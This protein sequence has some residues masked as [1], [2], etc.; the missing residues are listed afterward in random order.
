MELLRLRSICRRRISND[1][2]AAY[3]SP[4]WQKEEWPPHTPA[5]EPAG[6][7][8]Y[9]PNRQ[10]NNNNNFTFTS[11]TKTDRDSCSPPLSFACCFIVL[12]A[13]WFKIGL[14]I[15]RMISPPDSHKTYTWLDYTIC[16]RRKQITNLCC[17]E[18]FSN[19]WCTIINLLHFGNDGGWSV[20]LYRLYIWMY[21]IVWEGH[22]KVSTES[23]RSATE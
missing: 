16:I 12:S 9:Q 20:V 7:L 13:G 17:S 4:L 15:K 23:G 8:K 10:P 11:T 2:S 21:F 19:G 14:A 22:A 6:A 1:D 18:D 3:V 5:A